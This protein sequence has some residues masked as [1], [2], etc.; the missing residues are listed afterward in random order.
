MDRLSNSVG[1][2]IIRN[3]EP[4]ESTS[5]REAVGEILGWEWKWGA[6]W[7][8]WQ[9]IRTGRTDSKTI[10]R[11]KASKTAVLIYPHSPLQIFRKLDKC[12]VF[13]PLSNRLPHLPTPLPTPTLTRCTLGGT[14]FC[15]A[16]PLGQLT[17]FASE[18][19]KPAPWRC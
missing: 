18:K 11:S 14:G 8:Q 13:P 7:R 4:R 16:G 9:C 19:L 15:T 17:L 5:A 2:S 10:E 6:Y 1:S 3:Q 12:E